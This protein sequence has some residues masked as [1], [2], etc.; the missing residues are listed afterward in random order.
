MLLP[1]SI[2]IASFSGILMLEFKKSVPDGE[3]VRG[4]SDRL[5]I[6]RRLKGVRCPICKWQPDRE[7]RWTCWDCDHPEYFYNGCG[8][9]WNTFETGG[10]CPTCLH[11]WIWTSCLACWGWSKH[12]DWYQE[13]PG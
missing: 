5:E 11:Q 9:D 13:E 2:S 10:Q 1:Y 4:I 6:D 12:E 7:S 8:T 3:P